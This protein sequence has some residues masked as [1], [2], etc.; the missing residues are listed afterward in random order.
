[1]KGLRKAINRH[2]DY[3]K[4]ELK[5]IKRRQEKLDNSIAETKAEL[6]TINSRLNNEEE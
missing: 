5:T 4:K 6:V 3:C 1:M 2:A